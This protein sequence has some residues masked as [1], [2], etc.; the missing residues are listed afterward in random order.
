[1]PFFVGQPAPQQ[2]AE[3]GRNEND[4]HLSDLDPEIEADQRAPELPG[5]QAELAEETGKTKA[6]NQA[7]A[8]NHDR[9]PLRHLP[10]CQVFDGDKGDRERDQR[11]DDGRGGRDHSARGQ[12]Q[13]RSMSHGERGDLPDERLDANRSKEYR[14]HEEDVVGAVGQD[15]PDADRDVEP[16]RRPEAA[17]FSGRVENR[18]EV[19]LDEVAARAVELGQRRAQRGVETIVPAAEL[20]LGVRECEAAREQQC[21]DE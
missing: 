7:E 5:R 15:M 13:R 20:V 12:C 18:V 14:Q 1:M 8:E 3:S 4:R 10:E 2:H 19:G 16:E 21:Q 9:P 6:M 17:L 11:F